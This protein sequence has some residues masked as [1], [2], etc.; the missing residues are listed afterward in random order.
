V[1]RKRAAALAALGVLALAAWVGLAGFGSVT[2]DPEVRYEV[3][4]GSPTVQVAHGL[5]AAGVVRHAWALVAL[6]RLRGADRE[7]RYGTHVFSG[8]MSPWAVLDE[9]TS[10]A[11]DAV[12]VTIPEGLTWAEAGAI[13]EQ[14]GI[15]SADDY[16]EAVCDPKFLALVGAAPEANCA[17]G[18]LFPDTYVVSPGMSAAGVARLQHQRFEEVLDEVMNE[19]L[20]SSPWEKPLTEGKISLAEVR[21]QVVTLASIIE[22]ETSERDEGSLVSAVFHNRLRRGMKLQAD[23]TVIYALRVDGRDWDGNLTRANL[24]EPSA[25]NTYVNTGLPPGPICNPGQGALM[26]ALAPADSDFLYFVA[27]GDGSHRFSKTLSEHNRAVRAHQA[28]N[29]SPAGNDSAN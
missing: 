6:A 25:Y 15:V 26:N 9:L 24:R 5:E 29:H 11:A 16:R 17:E 18:F 2:I 21:R 22:K 28:R 12:R 1:S 4:S 20:A 19:A 8:R 23:P 3:I 7:I 10:T 27:Q 13:L 14:S